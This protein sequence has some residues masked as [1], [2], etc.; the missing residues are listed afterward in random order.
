MGPGTLLLLLLLLTG[1][2]GT[3]G[4]PAVVTSA[5]RNVDRSIADGDKAIGGRDELHRHLDAAACRPRNALYGTLPEPDVFSREQLGRDDG[6]AGEQDRA[7]G[8][9]HRP[10]P[11]QR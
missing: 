5:G 9:H 2:S 1:C 6:G 3:S 10:D 4:T 11:G 7:A 8:R